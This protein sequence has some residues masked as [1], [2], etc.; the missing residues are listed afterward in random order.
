LAAKGLGEQIDK[1][2]S[3]SVAL[4]VVCSP[5]AVDSPWV[6]HEIDHFVAAGRR[7]RIFA[8]IPDTAPLFDDS[9]ADATPLCLPIV[10]HDAAEGGGM[11]ILAA[12]S[13]K[14][15]D[16]FRNACFKLVAGMIGVRPGQIIDRDRRRRHVQA[17]RNIAAAATVAIGVI[18]AFLTQ[19]LW[20]PRLN[21]S[22]HYTWF[23]DSND[24]LAA[25]APRSTFQDCRAPS[26]YCPIMVVLPGGVAEIGSAESDL[27]RVDNELPQQAISIT[28][29]AVSQTEI[30]FA[31]WNACVRGGGCNAYVPHTA[32]WQGEQ[33]PVINVSWDDAQNYVTWLSSMTGAPYRLLSDVEWE[34]A[35]RAGSK[36]L[37]S[38]GDEPP[39]C[40]RG[41]RNGAAS[42]NCSPHEGT[43][44]VR[45]FEPNAF[46][47]YDFHGNVAEWVEDCYTDLMPGLV[48]CYRIVRGGHWRSVW[49]AVRA[50]A[51]DALPESSQENNLGFRV[52]RTIDTASSP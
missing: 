21:Q 19:D 23:V 49:P 8:I 14:G 41:P 9:G 47:L 52:A 50:S 45:S 31:E 15:R 37:F 42:Y 40:Q 4:V 5:N 20:G 28:P 7:D 29:F 11:A 16:G 10:F 12:D 18:A 48:D 33:R 24:A 3:E 38:W 34:Y 30:T 2:L 36:G 43:W 25:A 32:G 46:G 22:L 13:R 51:R 44:E 17:I 39:V 26:T 35:A 1:A 27:A 6:Q